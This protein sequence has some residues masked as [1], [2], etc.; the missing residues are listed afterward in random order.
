MLLDPINAVT[1]IQF[2]RR[3][4]V[5]PWWRS[6]FYL[7]YLS[8]FFSLAFAVSLKIHAGPHIDATFEWLKKEAPPM[9]FVNGKLTSG[10]SAPLTLRHP[11]YTQ[12]A[13]V[14]DTNRTDPVTE[15]T[16]A[17]AKVQAFLTSTSFYMEERPGVVRV[18]NFSTAVDPKPMAIDAAFYESSRQIF[19]RVLYP[20]IFIA[21]IF[22]C[23]AW[24]GAATLVF[25]L[26]GLL[27]N[28]LVEGGVAF[29]PLVH[30]ALYA[31]TLSTFLQALSFLFAVVVPAW[32]AI[33]LVITGAYIFLAIRA[34]R[35]PEAA[36]V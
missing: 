16:L 17:D 12:I 7:A 32:S 30:I 23:F 1:S 15:K 2:Y 21:G 14:I 18:Y 20:S 33:S 5:Q 34:L 8:V 3:V 36:A 13:I 19:D 22:I 24:K 10:L 11:E 35:E 4:A 6:A 28:A 9:T 27:L 29:A 26:V 31:Q 25:S